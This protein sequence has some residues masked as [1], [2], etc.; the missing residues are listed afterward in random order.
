M[1]RR[2]SLPTSLHGAPR[3]A[4]MYGAPIYVNTGLWW[5][6]HCAA[7]SGDKSLGCFSRFQEKLHLGPCKIPCRF[8]L[9]L[10]SVACSPKLEVCT[11]AKAEA[12]RGGQGA[13]PIEARPPASLF[14]CIMLHPNQSVSRD[15]RQSLIP[16]RI[17]SSA[18]FGQAFSEC[19]KNG[20]Y[21]CAGRVETAVS[22]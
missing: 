7:P 11:P 3:S 21:S 20:F 2:G 17:Q 1:S 18:R 19:E 4:S 10:S 22:S 8:S 15:T 9:A 13:W 14:G 16:R 5:W 6:R 12:R